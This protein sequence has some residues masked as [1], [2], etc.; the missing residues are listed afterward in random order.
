MDTLRNIA[1]HYVGPYPVIFYLGLVGYALLLSTAG[2]MGMS[3]VLKRRR[4]VKIH[5]RLAY[6][7]LLVA[8]LHALLGIATRI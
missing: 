4:P 6:A 8:T 1:Y 7:T 3:R 2:A 5:R